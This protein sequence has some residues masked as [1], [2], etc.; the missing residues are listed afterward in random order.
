MTSRPSGTLYETA[1]KASFSLSLFS[2]STTDKNSQKTPSRSTLLHRTPALLVDR[3]RRRPH[4]LGID[5][6]NNDVFVLVDVSVELLDFLVPADPQF[7]ADGVDELRVL[8]SSVFSHPQR[9][10]SLERGENGRVGKEE[11]KR[12]VES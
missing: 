4:A 2:P 3:R 1:T 7:R 10:S 11:G 12:T 9:R 8:F 5:V 6:V